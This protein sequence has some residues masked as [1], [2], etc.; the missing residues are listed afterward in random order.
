MSDNGFRGSRVVIP[1]ALFFAFDVSNSVHGAGY[2]V[3]VSA[4]RDIPAAWSDERFVLDVKAFR[5]SGVVIPW[6]IDRILVKSR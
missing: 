1:W 3:K 4:F 2:T 5:G 6:A